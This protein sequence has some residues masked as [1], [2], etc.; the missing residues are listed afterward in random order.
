MARVCLTPCTNGSPWLDLFWE[1]DFEDFALETSVPAC[2]GARSS[3]SHVP[4]LAFP[5]FETFLPDA[6]DPRFVPFKAAFV[7]GLGPFV[8]EPFAQGFRVLV[9]PRAGAESA[10]AARDAE[11]TFDHENDGSAARL[12]CSLCSGVSSFGISMYQ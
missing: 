3:H 6:A 11:A 10:F 2:T 5:L 1:L 8:D 4:T 7:L 12:F 9:E